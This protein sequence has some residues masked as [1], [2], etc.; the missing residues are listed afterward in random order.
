MA[1]AGVFVGRAPPRPPPSMAGSASRSLLREKSNAT[2]TRARKKTRVESRWP[3]LQVLHSTDHLSN[4]L[5]HQ[6]SLVI[7]ERYDLK[8]FLNFWNG[9]LESPQEAGGRKTTRKTTRRA[10]MIQLNS[11]LFFL[12]VFIFHTFLILHGNGLKLSK[13]SKYLQSD[14]HCFGYHMKHSE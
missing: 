3:C 10:A 6:N 9:C 2:V 12:F 5:H 1:R 14:R 8:F 13:N 11:R 4:S 7:S